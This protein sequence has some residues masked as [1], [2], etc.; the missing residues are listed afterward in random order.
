MRSHARFRPG[1]ATFLALVAWLPCTRLQAQAAHPTGLEVGA[2]PAINF[3]S[4][5]GFG[6]GAIAELYHY[7]DGT[8]DPYVWTIQPTVFL[9]TEG[10][11]DVTL[12]IDA[13]HVLPG[14][15]RIDA[16][17]ASERHIA[18]PYYGLGNATEYDPSL[19]A[20]DGPDPH[21]YRFGRTRRS[22]SVNVQHRL[23]RDEVRVLAGVGAARTSVRAVP[24][25]R[26]TTLWAL[27]WG[28]SGAAEWSNH[29]RAG[30]VWDT[31]DRE[32]GPTRGSWTELLV[33]HVDRALGSDA[34]W[35]RWTFADRRYLSP[36]P[37]LTLAHRYLLQGVH[38]DAPVY[39]LFR[40]QT[41]FKQQEGLGGAKSLR[42]VLKNRWV[43]RGM[44]IW[45]IELRWRAADFRLWGRPFHTVLSA[46][47]DQG[48]VWEDGVHLDEVFT[49]LHRGVGG[50]VR[51]GMGE[52]FVVAVDAGT[53]NETGLP[54]YI[55]LGYLY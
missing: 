13:P 27:D 40:V 22:V 45:N 8:Q 47:L 11:R 6:Y 35:T 52:N 10:R 4:D 29:V 46:F 32:S 54:I 55:G 5:E 43:G 31:R 42:G 30:L 34:T 41:S 14:G 9:T 18:T 28:D 19:E 23:A 33:Q 20:E 24:E 49:D 48:R 39:E 12:F 25:G 38:G 50:G 17:L 2:L 26:G 3:D 53:S 1:N 51:L 15:W 7:G 36:T 37:R 21:Y 44:L 16:A